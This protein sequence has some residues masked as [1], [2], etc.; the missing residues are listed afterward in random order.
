MNR[1]IR[2]VDTVIGIV[3]GGVMGWYHYPWYNWLAL[4]FLLWL[5]N[6]IE[7]TQSKPK[8]KTKQ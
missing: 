6:Y 2:Q 7:R 1:M 5:W 8:G 3:V 4:L